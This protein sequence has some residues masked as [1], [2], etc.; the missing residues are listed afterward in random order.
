[1]GNDKTKKA[2]LVVDDN[3]THLNLLGVKLSRK[4]YRLIT[5]QSGEEALKAIELERPGLVLLDMMMPKMS[6]IEVLKKIKG[7]DS[8]IPV[9]MVTAVWDKEEGKKCFEAGA[10]EYITKPVDF[11]RLETAILVKLFD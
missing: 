11:N 6:G 1:M 9:A 4:G 5:A 3:P 8:E 7:I 10:Y 2:I